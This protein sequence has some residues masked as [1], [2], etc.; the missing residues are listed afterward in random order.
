MPQLNLFGFKHFSVNL[1]FVFVKNHVSGVIIWV[2]L[3]CQ[4]TP[5]FMLAPN[6]DFHFVRERVAAN[7]LAI[8]FIS[9][10]DQIA[11]GFTKALPVKGLLEFCRNLN[12]SRALD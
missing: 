8:K 6:I 3:I 12:L 11:D 9:T 4:L 10:K 7:R 2:L 1:V 5:F